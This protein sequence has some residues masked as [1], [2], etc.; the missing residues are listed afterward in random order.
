MLEYT[1]SYTIGHITNL[2][3]RY[4]PVCEGG[5]GRKGKHSEK[6]TARKSLL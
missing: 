2:R 4:W 1:K 5:K 3:D 6:N